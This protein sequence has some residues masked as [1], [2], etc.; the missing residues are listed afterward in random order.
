MRGN[1][2]RCQG[3]GCNVH[4][5]RY[6]WGS[7]VLTTQ[8]SIQRALLR[9]FSKSSPIMPCDRWMGLLQNHPP[10][11][12]VEATFLVDVSMPTLASSA[13]VAVSGPQLVSG[14]CQWDYGV[15]LLAEG[16]DASNNVLV[17]ITSYVTSQGCGLS[18]N[19]FTRASRRLQWI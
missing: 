12:A 17:C 2:W 4:S 8:R 7:V 13:C 9:M 6:L 14:A 11:P 16:T 19:G 5:T 10:P 1:R 3:H 18:P 15:P